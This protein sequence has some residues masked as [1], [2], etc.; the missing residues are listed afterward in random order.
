M[1]LTDLNNCLENR[2]VHPVI[3][4]DGTRQQTQGVVG[5]T[6]NLSEVHSPIIFFP[7]GT[8]SLHT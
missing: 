5:M 7:H 2:F 4:A 8:G 6:V 3:V 1:A